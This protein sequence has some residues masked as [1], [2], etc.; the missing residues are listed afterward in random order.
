M[1]WDLSLERYDISKNRYRELLNFCRQ[2]PEWLEELSANE[3]ALQSVNLSGMPPSGAI[4]DSTGS[5][6]TRRAELSWKCEMVEQSA[7][8]ANADIYQEIIKNVTGT[9]METS[10]KTQEFRDSRRYF[11]WLL[12]KKRK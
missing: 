6:A 3:D 12:D 2:Y 7:I 8:M 11:F 1:E 4:S 10:K 9:Q 5:L